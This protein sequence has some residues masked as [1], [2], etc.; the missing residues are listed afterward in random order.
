MS[1]KRPTQEQREVVAEDIKA[2]G[3]S[4]VELV[5]EEGEGQGIM[6][7]TPIL[8]EAELEEAEGGGPVAEAVKEF[9]QQNADATDD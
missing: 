3:V 4:A 9:D 5:M 6:G 2:G 1:T 7:G 8:D